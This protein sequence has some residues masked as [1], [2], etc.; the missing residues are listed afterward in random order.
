LNYVIWLL[1]MDYIIKQ[2]IRLSDCAIQYYILYKFYFLKKNKFYFAKKLTFR[3]D[4]SEFLY[5]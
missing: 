2:S 5:I 3:L 4:N 1:L